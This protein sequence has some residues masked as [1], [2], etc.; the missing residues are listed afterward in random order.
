MILRTSVRQNTVLF[1]QLCNIA[2]RKRDKLANCYVL[3]MDIRN[4]SEVS[5]INA[6]FDQ[7]TPLYIEMCDSL[8]MS[9][10]VKVEI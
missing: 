7:Y 3:R 8:G 10:T 1:G 2:N 9:G 5:Q 4:S 6:Y